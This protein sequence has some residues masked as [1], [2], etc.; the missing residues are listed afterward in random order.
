MRKPKP[1]RAI[2]LR[3]EEIRSLIKTGTARVRRPISSGDRRRL[4]PY[5]QVGDVLWVKEGWARICTDAECD[6]DQHENDRYHYIEFRA[7]VPDGALPGGWPPEEKGNPDR[8]QWWPS[9]QMRP[10]QSRLRVD[11]TFARC[12]N[13]KTVDG[14]WRQLWVL[15]LKKVDD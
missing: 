7:D 1:E 15:V 9:T 5:G 12:E 6:G 13:Q 4:C 3:S 8:P 11:V 2:N 10:E 14:K